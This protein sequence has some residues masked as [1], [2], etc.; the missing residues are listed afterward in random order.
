MTR[1]QSAAGD[2]TSPF[3]DSIGNQRDLLSPSVY[4]YKSM[5]RRH[6]TTLHASTRVESISP[7]TTV[8]PPTQA[9]DMVPKRS[10]LPHLLVGDFAI[11]AFVTATVA[12]A[13]TV[14]D[15]ALVERS[16]LSHTLLQ[17]AQQ[18]VMGMLRNPL[19]YLK[20]PTFLW[21]WATY[22]STYAAANS[23]RTLMEYRDIKKAAEVSNDAQ[24]TSSSTAAHPTMLLF[25][26]TTI[27]NSS[28]SVVK[29]RAYAQLF[30]NAMSPSVPTMSYCLW[31]ARDCTV[32]GSS[33]VL[34]PI[35]SRVIQ[36]ND[37]LPS[38]SSEQTLK[39]AQIV[40]PATAQFWPVHCILSAWIGSIDQVLLFR[41]R[42]EYVSCKKHSSKWYRRALPA[43]YLDM[44]WPVFGIMIFAL[45]GVNMLSASVKPM[46]ITV[47]GGRWA[48][49]HG[50]CT[51]QKPRA[52]QIVLVRCPCFHHHRQSRHQW[53]WQQHAQITAM[54]IVHDATSR[55]HVAV[56]CH[57]QP[58]R[59]HT[60]VN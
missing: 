48:R 51:M 35:V 23:L 5:I 50:P 55:G 52:L 38:L 13:L 37:L 36:E 46:T 19:A 47:I 21:M 29:D 9:N 30:G 7:M 10:A 27:V 18:S 59:V 40:S 22:A 28:A 8:N 15:K 45:R 26:G 25:V 2:Q 49:C 42:N 12:P 58:R 32:V 1:N 60:P 16:A 3:T 17:S 53:C 39:V 34:P 57:V 11:A 31:I 6:V 54:K 24:E 44:V 33:F 14:V 4:G 43:S 41:C 56:A 20:S